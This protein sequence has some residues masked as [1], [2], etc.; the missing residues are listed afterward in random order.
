MITLNLWCA[1]STLYSYV[2]ELNSTQAGGYMFKVPRYSFQRGSERF[3]ELV[4][5]Q[6]LRYDGTRPPI[7]LPEYITDADF[8]RFLDVLYPM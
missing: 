2:I 8:E 1:V 5:A 6:D 4:T 3:R 7:A